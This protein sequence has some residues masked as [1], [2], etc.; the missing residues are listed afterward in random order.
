MEDLQRLQQGSAMERHSL[1][2]TIVFQVDSLC[3]PYGMLCTQH[4]KNPSTLF[5]ANRASQ[6]L[7]MQSIRLQV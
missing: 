5:W 7:Q 4:G 2:G 3:N 6:I 1:P